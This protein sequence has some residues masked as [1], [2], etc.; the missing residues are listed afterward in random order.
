[1]GHARADVFRRHYMHQT[2]KVDIQSAY[3][4][5]TKRADL[6]KTISLMRQ[7]DPR[8]PVELDSENHRLGNYPELSALKAERKRLTNILKKKCGTVGKAKVLR[9]EECLEH[10]NLDRQIRT[11]QKRLSRSALKDLRAKFFDDT[12]QDEIQRQLGGQDASTFKYAK[13]EFHC[14]IRSQISEAFS[15]VEAM[16]LDRWSETVCALSA[17]C[18]KQPRI[19]AKM[20]MGGENLC[21][22]CFNDDKLSPADRFHSF[23]SSGTLKTHINKRHSPTTASES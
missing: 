2:V 4:G 7:H 20:A 19:H 15:S 6:M 13:P 17:L 9:P 10:T 5:T 8:A 12:D 11:T 22:F 14:P 3:L 21:S 1:M 18:A 16:T 23:F